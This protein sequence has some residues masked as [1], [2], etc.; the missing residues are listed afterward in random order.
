VDLW[1]QSLQGKL[2]LRSVIV[3]V[4]VAVFFLFL[5]VKALEARRWS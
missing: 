4:S 2:Y 5:T 1:F 3:Q